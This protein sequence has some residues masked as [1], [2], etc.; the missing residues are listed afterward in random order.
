LPDPWLTF[1]P[2]TQSS[3][4]V[5]PAAVAA[6][7]VVLLLLVFVVVRRRRGGPGGEESDSFATVGGPYQAAARDPEEPAGEHPRA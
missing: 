2:G 6:A 7:V 5:I 1:E 4:A 3:G